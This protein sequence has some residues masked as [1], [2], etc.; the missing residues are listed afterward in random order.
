MCIR[1][2]NSTAGRLNVGGTIFAA[3]NNSNT[4]AMRTIRVLNIPHGGGGGTFYYDFDPVAIFGFSP[5]GGH[6]EINVSGWSQRLNAGY[7]NFQNAG[8]GAPLTSVTFVQSAFQAGNGGATISV[9]MV[10]GGV[11]N[12]IR[13]TFT[14][15]HGNSH[16]WNAWISSPQS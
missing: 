15:W 1:D 10:N 14:G 8:G 2:S 5:T 7:I 11:T 6:V 4:A 3:Q 16:A 13:V 12:V 9:S